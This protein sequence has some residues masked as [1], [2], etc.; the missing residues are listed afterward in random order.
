MSTAIWGFLVFLDTVTYALSKNIKMIKI[1]HVVGDSKA[2]FSDHVIPEMTPFS[3]SK[4]KVTADW[5]P[6]SPITAYFSLFHDD[7]VVKLSFVL[8]KIASFMS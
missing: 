4:S 6:F 1:T 2:I 7:D 5:C 3:I 8:Y